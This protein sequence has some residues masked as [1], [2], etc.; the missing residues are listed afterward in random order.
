MS[1]SPSSS[2]TNPLSLSAAITEST[3][4]NPESVVS[5]YLKTLHNFSSLLK[6]IVEIVAA[7]NS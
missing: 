6:R 1:L 7:K 3:V 2:T 5:K 4:I